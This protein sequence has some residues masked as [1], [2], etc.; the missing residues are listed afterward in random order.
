[1]G[2][3]DK[4]ARH[5]MTRKEVLMCSESNSQLHD[6]SICFQYSFTIEVHKSS[7]TL[8]HGS[9]QM[10]LLHDLSQQGHKKLCFFLISF[11]QLCLSLLDRPSTTTR[12]GNN[13]SSTSNRY[14]CLQ[15]SEATRNGSF[16]TSAEFWTARLAAGLIK[17]FFLNI[18]ASD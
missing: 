5:S 15:P 18:S 11:S 4:R 7:C 3:V 16:R 9:I 14:G 6:F 17:F 12:N 10:I 8:P 13:E 2:L 1:M